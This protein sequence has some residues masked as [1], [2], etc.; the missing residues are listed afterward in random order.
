MRAGCQHLAQLMHEV[1]E[2]LGSGNAT[3]RLKSIASGAAWKAVSG[4]EQAAGMS[5]KYKQFVVDGTVLNTAYAAAISGGPLSP[6][7]DALSKFSTDCQ[8]EG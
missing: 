3:V 2:A 6:L 7:N 8:K 5:G 1:S 4:I